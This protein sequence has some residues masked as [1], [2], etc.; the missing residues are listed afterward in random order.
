MT[1]DLLFLDEPTTGQDP[2]RSRITRE[3]ILSLKARGKTIF[4]TTHNMSEAEEVCDR[5]GFLA[6]GR[7]PVTGTPEA[8]KRQ[9]G[10]RMLEVGIE[11]GDTMEKRSFP[12]EGIGANAGFL[13]LLTA[14]R[15]VSMHTL[16]ASLDEVFIKAMAAAVNQE[17]V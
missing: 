4:L 5:V 8:L 15:V 10:R 6:N 14:G 3:L 12:M 9:F 13:Q 7:I 17:A 2:A 1:P 16:E 11:N